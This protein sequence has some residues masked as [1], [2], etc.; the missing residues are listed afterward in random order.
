[1]I[2]ITGNFINAYY[3]CER[4]LWLFAHKI[5][6]DVNHPL[7]ELGRLYDSYSYK[8]D[9]KEIS[10]DGMKIDLIK[11]RDGQLVIGELKKSSKFELSAKMQLVY[12]LYRLKEQGI[13]L[14]G[15]LLIPK[16]KK[17]KRVVLND[18]LIQELEDIMKDIRIIIN[19]EKAPVKKMI[20]YCKSCAFYD[21]C[22]S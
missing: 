19:K 21:F 10:A 7:L 2:Q 17:R 13:N 11:W 9:K 6:P 1:M 3:V 5:D 4:K 15:E 18:D 16:E 12:Y 14:E 22:W 8:R 20:K